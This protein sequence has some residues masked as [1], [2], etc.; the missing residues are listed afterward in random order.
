MGKRFGRNQRRKLHE[1]I[2]RAQYLQAMAERENHYLR[3]ALARYLM[4]E[5]ASTNNAP[6]S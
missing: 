3:E 1:Q 2:Y 4:K 5:K 6:K